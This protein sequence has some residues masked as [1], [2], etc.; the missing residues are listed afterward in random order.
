MLLIDVSVSNGG[1]TVLHKRRA[2]K[3]LTF[4]SCIL[5]T[6]RV[7]WKNTPLDPNSAIL[8]GVADVDGDASLSAE[9]EESHR[10]SSRDK[11]LNH[12]RVGNFLQN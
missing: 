8:V 4:G 10:D 7:S 6:W 2:D 1:V 5:T 11:P 12:F 3:I 9:V